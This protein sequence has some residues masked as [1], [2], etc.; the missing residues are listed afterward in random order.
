M[1]RREF[2]LSLCV[3]AVCGY[4]GVD[5]RCYELRWSG[6]PIEVEVLGDRIVG[7]RWQGGE[8][9]QWV[10]ERNGWEVWGTDRSQIR[11]RTV[12][13]EGEQVVQVDWALEY[14]A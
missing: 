7:V 12:K 1:N 11:L 5:L 3:L 2:G 6:S 8:C 13:S 14:V 4:G 10:R 9:W